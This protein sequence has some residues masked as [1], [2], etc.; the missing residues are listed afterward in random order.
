[1]YPHLEGDVI[2]NRVRDL[3]YARE[4]PAT[5]FASCDGAAG[6]SQ[7]EIEE[8]YL[9]PMVED[10]VFGGVPADRTIMAP[11]ADPDGGFIN[12]QRLARRR[13]QLAAF[14]KFVKTN[15]ALF[16]AKD[17]MPVRL[18]VSGPA[19]LHSQLSH[20]SLLAAEGAALRG[21][22]PF[23]YSISTEA[24]LLPHAEDAAVIVVANQTCLSDAQVAALVSYAKKGGRLVC[25]GDSGRY[26]EW[27]R[28]RHT[29]PLKTAVAKLPNV[30]WRDEADS[31][32]MKY[33]THIKYAI[34][35]PVKGS[36]PF[37]A[38]LA[39]TGWKPS[40]EVVA[41]PETVFAQFKVA[42][43]DVASVHFVNY[44]FLH[45]VKG[46]RLR[47][48]AGKKPVFFAPLDD[49]AATGSPHEVSPGVW[50]LPPFVKYAYCT[51]E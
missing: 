26:D 22:V 19:M 32:K 51:V 6:D 10:V 14:Q 17:W 13:P 1:M 43:T 27:N 39:K 46:V 34:H 3:K 8:T 45:P 12:R 16:A 7:N 5:Y 29:N 40:L 23:G 48:P 9:L 44:E 42:G 28:Q 21:H 25:T 38:D 50:E 15:R 36:A 24:N 2:V 35:R 41:A 49:P 33:L 47:L 11:Y 37:L 18:L 30:A 20:E 31:A 4:F